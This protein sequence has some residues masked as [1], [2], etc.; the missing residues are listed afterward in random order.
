MKP[1]QLFERYPPFENRYN[2]FLMSL[3]TC[4]A[5]LGICLAALGIYSVLSYAV[6]QRT[7]EICVRMALGAQRTQM[8]KLVLGQAAPPVIG[9]MI[10]GLMS[11]IAVAIYARS[12]IPCADT[13]LTMRRE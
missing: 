10:L 6:G 7:R 11:T 8:V 9:G 13:S 12:R 5:V 3:Q 4:F 1:A 2:Y